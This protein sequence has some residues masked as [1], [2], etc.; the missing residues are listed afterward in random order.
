MYFNDLSEEEI[1]HYVHH[2]QPFDKAGA[3][4]I[5]E[6]IGFCKILR[7]E[8]TYTNIMELPMDLVYHGLEKFNH[9]NV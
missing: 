5:Q 6:W 4:G 2:Y 8:G 3:Y 7:I 1:D 9:E